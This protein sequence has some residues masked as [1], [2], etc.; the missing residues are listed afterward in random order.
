MHESLSSFKSIIEIPIAWGEMDAAQHVNNTVYLR[1]GESSRIAYMQHAKID[2]DLNGIGIILAEVQCKYKFPLTF[3]DTVWVGTRTL[4]ETIDDY[5]FWT[6][7]IIVS[8][9]FQRVSAVINAKLVCYDFSALKKAVIPEKSM[10][11]ILTF[12]NS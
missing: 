8:Q 1:Y 9:R 7:Q 6:E 4:I 3:P 12:E 11:S 10:T 2:F 5:G